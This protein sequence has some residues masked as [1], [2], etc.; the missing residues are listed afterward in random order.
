[1]LYL[2][3]LL[4]MFM[5]L[6][7][8]RA[9]LQNL[10]FTD[11]GLYNV[12]GGVIAMLGFINASLS[13]ASS[14]FITYNIE[15]FCKLKKVISTIKTIYYILALII[16]ILGETIGLWFILVQ[17]NIPPERITA[18]IWVYQ[19]SI[20]TTALNIICTPYNALIIAKEKISIYAII[21]LIDSLFRML[22][23]ISIPLIPCDGLI[24]YA[25]AY[26]FIIILERLFIQL[27]TWH[28][29]PVSKIRCKLYKNE[30]KQ[31][32]GFSF[33]TV[34]GNLAILCYTEGLNILLNIFFGS[35]VNAAR[36]IAV[37]V[38]SVAMQFC[39]NF[40]IA[41]NPQIIKSYAMSDINRMHE[42]VYASSK[43]SFLLISIIVTPIL[44][45]IED[46]LH[47]WLGKVPEHT[48][49][50]VR[51]TLLTTL[52]S[53]FSNPLVTSIQATGKIKKFQIYEGSCLL[54]VIP[55][56]LLLLNFFNTQPISV[57][58][59]NFVIAIIAQC[60]RIW[61][62]LPEIGMS[63]NLYL[64]IVIIPTILAFCASQF[65][66]YIEF[67]YLPNDRLSTPFII[68]ISSLLH[69]SIC[70]Y[71]IGCT[72]KEKLFITQKIRSYVCKSKNA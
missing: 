24:F 53:A 27:Y 9:L 20:M 65:I 60:V 34:N 33:W 52:I 37:Q 61:I 13:S 1:M 14:R 68:V 6:Y 55:I 28:R 4:S 58:I 49:A 56:S 39:S 15:D 48:G 44:Y 66:P 57:F 30:G 12:V 42:L 2:R 47:L 64:K 11:Y 41:I 26:M 3:M 8:S 17:L 7:S 31:L 29:F 16:I 50:F 18:C 45:T 22:A 59:V 36:S 43:F 62:V 5:G 71:F 72:A 69:S 70:I 25:V 10:G 38:Q 63:I 21:T 32:L 23:A 19:C 35:I 46:I 40:Q 51:I 67:Q 54:A